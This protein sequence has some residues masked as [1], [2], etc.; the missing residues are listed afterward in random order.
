AALRASYTLARPEWERDWTTEPGADTDDEEDEVTDA[1]SQSHYSPLAS[2]S[3]AS[4]RRA[5]TIHTTQ[6]YTG[7]SPYSDYY[8]D[9]QPLPFAAS[10][11]GSH[12][13]P[14][15]E[16]PLEDSPFDEDELDASEDTER[17]RKKRQS[18][19]R[20]SVLRK[21]RVTDSKEDVVTEDIDG[22]EDAELDG[23]MTMDKED[24]PLHK[25]RFTIAD[26]RAQRVCGSSG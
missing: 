13:S 15:T 18:S 3:R 10:P 11:S 6:P 21:R 7:Y 8:A 2:A 22:S 5:V 12:E 25:A 4:P 24:G 1:E 20:S 14:I 17:K 16:S 23:D 9:P 19:G 26:H